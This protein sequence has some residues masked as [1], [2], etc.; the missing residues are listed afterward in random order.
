MLLHFSPGQTLEF[1]I[2][3]PNVQPTDVI[4]IKSNLNNKNVAF[5]VRTCLWR[6]ISTN[7]VGVGLGFRLGFQTLLLH[8]TMQKFFHCTDSKLNQIQI[9]FPDGYCTHFR[10]GSLSQGQISVP[11]TYIS[12]RGS[13]S[14]SKPVEKSCIVQESMSV[15]ESESTSGSGNKP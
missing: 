8:C 13:V 1:C 10:D 15:S 12:V 7:G 6:L 11:I 2:T 3:S 14:E 4:S 5:K 9:P